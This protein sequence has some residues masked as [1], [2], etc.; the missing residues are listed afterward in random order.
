MSE[1]LGETE[2]EFSVYHFA[3]PKMFGE[4]TQCARRYVGP[5]EAVKVAQHY[6]TSVA[7]R[8]GWTVRVIIVDSGDCVAFEWI[9]GKGYTTDGVNWT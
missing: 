7:A 9:Y 4:I 2:G 8:M 3:D 6:C 5:E 1:H